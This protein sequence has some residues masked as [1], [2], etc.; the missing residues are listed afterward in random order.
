[1]KTDLISD[2]IM[3]AN[4]HTY[5]IVLLWTILMIV[6]M[7]YIKIYIIN[8]RSRI[9]GV[10][11]KHMQWNIDN[12]GL[13]NK[14]LIEE[15]NKRIEMLKEMNYDEWL[16]YNNKHPD[17]VID[18]YKYNIF[19]Y[20]R[21]KNP[22]ANYDVKDSFIL[23]ANKN[24]EI[25]GLPY[26]ELLKLANYT[27]LFTIFSPNVNFLSNI[28]NGSQYK[29]GINIYSYYTVDE[30][31]NR[32]VKS[33][34]IAGRFTKTQDDGEVFDGLLYFPYSLVDI[35]EQYANKYYDFTSKT[36]MYVV[37]I[38]ILLVTLVLRYIV[39]NDDYVWLPYVFL[40]TAVY[41]LI[42]FIDTIEGI[43]NLEGENERTKEINDGILSIS[44]LAAVN[45]FIIQSIRDNKKS[46]HS[47]YEAAILFMVGLILLLISL[48]KITNYNRIDEL[49]QHRIVKQFSYNASVYIN[50]FIL[51]YY[52]FYVIR[53]S[54]FRQQ[55]YTS[56]NNLFYRKN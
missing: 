15:A 30:N 54:T 4:T 22:D 52:S 38:S 55:I 33:N 23:R 1:M 44:F 35:E 29:E 47:Y 24:Q 51:L 56:M 48:Y 42:S 11:T 45:V 6:Q 2:I 27:F 34:V 28:Y 49:R 31:I 9:T 43:T 25:L 10:K 8:W 37:S 19:V 16:N 7:Y 17:V 50:I 36:F 14:T 39:G 32:P 18:K 46:K 13:I 26:D 20:E 40:V 12:K 41:Y 53:R 5:K 3:V 21:I